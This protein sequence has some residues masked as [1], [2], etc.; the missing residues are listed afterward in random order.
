MSSLFKIVLSFVLALVISLSLSV[1]VYAQQASQTASTSAAVDRFELFW[2]LTAGKTSDQSLYFLKRLKENFRGMLIFGTAQKADYQVMLATKRLLEADKL[3]IDGK[4]AAAD[5][6]LQAGSE[7]LRSARLAMDTV[8]KASA[9]D[10]I[11]NM[12]KRLA[13]MDKLLVELQQKYSDNTRVQEML[14]LEQ[15]AASK[16]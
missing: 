9:A 6:T 14:K 4:T 8:D 15:E 7:S 1:S 5:E 12:Q 10:T 13:N 16:L 11:I 2:P 3:L